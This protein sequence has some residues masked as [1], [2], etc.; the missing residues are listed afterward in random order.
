[1]EH[2]ESKRCKTKFAIIFL[3]LAN[4]FRTFMVQNGY[5]MFNAVFLQT[6]TMKKLTTIACIVKIL[7]KIIPTFT[8]WNVNS[9]YYTCKH[10]NAYFIS[11]NSNVIKTIESWRFKTLFEFFHLLLAF[12]SACVFLG[13]SLL[14]KNYLVLYLNWWF[15]A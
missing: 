2:F 14:S 5:L 10:Q 8:N 12:Y 1:M 13:I 4:I 15:L 9:H 6:T 3:L 11:I 7:Q